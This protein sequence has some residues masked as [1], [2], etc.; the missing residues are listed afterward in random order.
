MYCTLSEMFYYVAVNVDGCKMTASLKRICSLATL[1]VKMLL[2]KFDML[3]VD[4]VCLFFVFNK[5]EVLYLH[6]WL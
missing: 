6:T 4:K 3:T 5:G 1:I 2:P